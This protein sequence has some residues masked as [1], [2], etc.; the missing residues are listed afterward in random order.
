MG[1]I[2]GSDLLDRLVSLVVFGERGTRVTGMLAL[3]LDCGGLGGY[4]E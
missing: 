2:W 1:C 4:N 3:E